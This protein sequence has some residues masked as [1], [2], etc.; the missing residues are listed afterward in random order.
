MNPNRIF[1]QDRLWWAL[2]DHP[3]ST[4]HRL[5]RLLGIRPVRVS[6]LLQKLRLRG[7]ARHEKWV[8]YA[9]GLA[10]PKDDRGVT[11]GTQQAL[12]AHR[13]QPRNQWCWGPGMCGRSGG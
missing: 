3:G 1:A 7:C 9:I 2:R 6:A 10:P 5:G 11:K 12:V 13:F 4:I 8:W